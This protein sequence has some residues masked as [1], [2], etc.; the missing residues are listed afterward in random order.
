MSMFRFKEKVKGT[1]GPAITF[2]DGML[3]IDCRPCRGASSL[4]NAEC[5]KCVS[6]SISDRGPPS[7]LLMRKESD[8]EYSEVVIS[9]LG[10]ISKI[11]S[12]MHTA[13]SEKLQAGCKDCRCSLPKNAK[14][15]WDSFP[16]PR[17]DILRLE[18]ERSNPNK[19]GCD[20]CAWRTIGFIDRSET[21]F[22]DLRKRC[23]KTAFRLTEV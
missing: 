10:E 22:A 23:A 21:L 5:V 7:R 12:L 14:E 18:T 2:D 6:S 20:E 11:S 17:F 19:D 3:F 15:I 13:S 16:E 1:N 9:I 8:I 4:G